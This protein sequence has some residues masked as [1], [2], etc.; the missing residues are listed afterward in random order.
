[1]KVKGSILCRHISLKRVP[2]GTCITGWSETEYLL[3]PNRLISEKDYEEW[4][5]KILD[6]EISGGLEANKVN[7]R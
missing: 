6:L 2:P 1:M 7:A 5:G 4:K 3:F